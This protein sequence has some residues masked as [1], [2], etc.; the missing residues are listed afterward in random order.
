MGGALIRMATSHGVA[1]GVWQLLAVG[2]ERAEQRF[3]EVH[4]AAGV[5]YVALLATCNS[6]LC[7][8]I[9]Y[10]GVRTKLSSK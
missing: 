9:S 3:A 7:V 2:D 5:E 4:G 6:Q 8:K 1:D 10:E